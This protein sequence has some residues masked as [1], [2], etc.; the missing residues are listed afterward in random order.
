MR[1]RTARQH[2]TERR[3]WRSRPRGNFRTLLMLSPSTPSRRVWSVISSIEVPQALRT[4][5]RARESGLIV[6][7]ALVG[8]FAGLIVTAMGFGVGLLHMLFGV[9]LGERLSA[10]TKLNPVVA[11]AVPT[12]G[13]MAF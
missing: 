11:L 6:V 7:A 13:G 1:I 8:V 3:N 2:C 10:A 9:P 12:L 5:V 4:L